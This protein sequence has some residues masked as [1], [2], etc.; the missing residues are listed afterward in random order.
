MGKEVTFDYSKAAGFVSAEEMANFKTTVMA[1]RDTLVEKTGAGNDYLGWIDLA[2]P[3]GECAGDVVARALPVFEEMARSGYRR[4]AVVTHGG[5]IDQL[6]ACHLHVGGAGRDEPQG[7][8]LPGGGQVGDGHKRCGEGPQPHISCR[9][10]QCKGNRKISHGNGEAVMG[11]LQIPVSI[12]LHNL[13]FSLFFKS[14]P[15]FYHPEGQE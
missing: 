14:P 12:A 6:R 7:C 3:G 11:A 10:A 2:Y 9:D 8:E 13:L 15:L 1:A 5:V 4:V